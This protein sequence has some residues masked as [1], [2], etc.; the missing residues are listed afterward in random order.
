MKD[1]PGTDLRASSTM[2]GGYSGLAA[3]I[4]INALKDINRYN[5]AADK[6]E[7]KLE[8]LAKKKRSAMEYLLSDEAA[9]FVSAAGI[10]GPL[11]EEVI[12]RA[13]K[14][15]RTSWNQGREK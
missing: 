11:T 7:K 15:L 10:N 9:V 4:V 12:E 8:K 5:V 2:D 1:L 3:A 14:D 6:S 13:A